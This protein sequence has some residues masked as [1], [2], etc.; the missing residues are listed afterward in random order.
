[1]LFACWRHEINKLGYLI[2]HEMQYLIK[3][4]LCST[5]QMICAYDWGDRSLKRY[6]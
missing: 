3:L 4:E 2:D 1:M 6:D 5:I